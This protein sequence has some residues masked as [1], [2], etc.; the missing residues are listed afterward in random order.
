MIQKT[1]NN[2]FYDERGYFI[3]T[4][5]KKFFNINFI[6][7]NFSLSKKEVIRGLHYQLNKPQTKLLSVLKGKIFDVIVDIRKSSENFGKIYE[8]YL[9]HKNDN[10]VLIPRGFAHGFQCLSAEALIYYKCDNYYYPDDQYGIH[11]NDKD[12]KIKWPIKKKIIVSQ[13]DQ[14]LPILSKNLNLFK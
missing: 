8:F 1:K 9:D 6:Q 14:D 11:Y 5:K 12:L 10:Q 2:I 13:N 4:F 3:E 7:D